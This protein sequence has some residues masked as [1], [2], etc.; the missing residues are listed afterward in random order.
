M[1]KVM[2]SSESA[3]ES[4]YCYCHSCGGKLVAELSDKAWQK[5][6]DRDFKHL[7]AGNLHPDTI[8]DL[9]NGIERTQQEFKRRKVWRGMFLHSN[10]SSTILSS[11]QATLPRSQ[12]TSTSQQASHQASR[13][14]SPSTSG[15]P[16]SQHVSQYV[17][18]GL[19]NDG[20]IFLNQII[21]N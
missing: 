18:P 20:K 15:I 2:T 3:A 17:T 8:N 9:R 19:E 1:P 14:A 10:L 13:C 12:R 16:T 4:F 7:A 5:H 6:I 11:I 21:Q